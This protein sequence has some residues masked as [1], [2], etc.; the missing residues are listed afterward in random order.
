MIRL[1]KR[2][3]DQV[4]AA[5][6]ESSMTHLALRVAAKRNDDGSFE[7]GM[8]FDEVHSD[9][10]R[11]ESEGVRVVV[12]KESKPLLEGAVVDFVELEEGKPQFIFLNPRD[13][14]YVPPVEGDIADV[15]A[16]NRD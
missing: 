12:S 15:P 9:D 3:A 11:I 16:K 8:G 5:A 6:D 2:A 7:Y 14:N 4:N 1:T 10:T 13:P